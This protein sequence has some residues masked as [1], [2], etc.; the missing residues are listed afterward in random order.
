MHN[1]W[2]KAYQATFDFIDKYTWPNKM[3]I[4]AK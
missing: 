1:N 3:G 2:L 4:D